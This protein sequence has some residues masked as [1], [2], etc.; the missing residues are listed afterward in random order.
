[1]LLSLLEENEQDAAT[2]SRQ[3]MMNIRMDEG[4]EQ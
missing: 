3:L 2:A 1:M 4:Q